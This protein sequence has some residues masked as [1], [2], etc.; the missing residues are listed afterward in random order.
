MVPILP[1]AKLMILVARYTRITPTAIRATAS[2][3]MTPVYTICELIQPTANITLEPRRLKT[4][5]GPGRL[6]R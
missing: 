2:P 5:L 1:T 3:W 6:A 4:Q